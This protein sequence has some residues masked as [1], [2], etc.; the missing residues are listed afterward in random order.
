MK[1][2]SWKALVVFFI[3]GGLLLLVAL[4]LSDPSKR[5]EFWIT[6]LQN[7]ALIALTVVLVEVLWSLIGKEPVRT[8]VGDLQVTLTELRQSV[9]L[10][11]DS[12]HSGL[13]RIY[14]TSG[15]AGS[16]EDWMNRLRDSSKAIDLMGYTLHVW[17]KGSHFE[18]TLADLAS[19]GVRIRILIMDE[20]NPHL[21]AFVNHWQIPGLTMESVTAELKAARGAFKTIAERVNSVK[22]PGALEFRVVKQGLISTQIVRTDSRI[23]AVQY[24]FHAVASRSPLIDVFGENSSLFQCYS[25]E[26]NSMWKLSIA[27]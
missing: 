21:E 14:A 17:T 8:A 23:T 3:V 24:L 11:D 27:G 6:V 16:N 18:E 25:E 22:P 9:Q 4:L 19:S 1:E 26:F 15:A 13:R 7:V 20:D 12:H 5:R 2:Q 10:L